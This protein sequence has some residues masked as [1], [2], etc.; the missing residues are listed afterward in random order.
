MD[1]VLLLLAVFVAGFGLY[2]WRY[3]VKGARTWSRPGA[4]VTELASFSYDRERGV[5]KVEGPSRH[6]ELKPAGVVCVVAAPDATFASLEELV[7]EDFDITDSLPQYRDHYLSFVI[8]LRWTGKLL[9]LAHVRQYRVS[10]VLQDGYEM[11]LTFLRALG[12]YRDVRDVAT[13]LR[14]TAVEEFG[15]MGLRVEFEEGV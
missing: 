6:V 3:R 10:D 1:L 11:R 14:A 2:A 7:F 5:I 4:F 13:E 15:G 9:P 8:A 12:L